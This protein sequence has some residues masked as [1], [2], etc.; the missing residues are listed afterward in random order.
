[1]KS[2]GLRKLLIALGALMVLAGISYG[3]TATEQMKELAKTRTAVLWFQGTPM[4]DMVIGSRAQLVFGWVDRAVVKL[5]MDNPGEFPD[6]LRQNVGYRGQAER[7]KCELFLLGYEAKKPWDF[8]PFKIAVN[9]RAL[10]KDRLYNNLAM[11]PVGE[12]IPGEMGVLAFGV[13]RGLLKPG[14]ALKFS[15]DGQEVGWIV[16]KR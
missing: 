2:M 12:M 8:D 4:G 6:V 7:D 13:P 16:P 11:I 1:M 3:A 10:T 9:G 15:Y 5:V 14:N